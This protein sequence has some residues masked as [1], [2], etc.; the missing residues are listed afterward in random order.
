M[1]V[2]DSKIESRQD[3]SQTDAYIP[4]T[5]QHIRLTSA[6][7]AELWA[8]Y[9]SASMQECLLSYFLAKV[10]DIEIRFVLENSLEFTKKHIQRISEIYNREKYP[11]PKGITGEDV[12]IEAPRLFS[13]I[14]ILSY[15]EFMAIT[16]IIGH[17]TALATSA[18]RD[19]RHYNTESLTNAAELYNKVVSALLSKGIYIRAPYVAIPEQI[20]FVKKQS[21]LTGFLGEKRPLSSIEVSHIFSL[22]KATLI[23]KTFLTGFSQVAKSQNVRKIMVRGKDI[24]SKHSKIYA[25]LLINND[26]PVPGLWDSGITESTVT[27]FSDKLIMYVSR[28]LEVLTIQ[29]LGKAISISLRRDLV[30]SYSRVLAEIIKFAEDRVNIMIENGWLEKPPLTA[31]R[32]ALV[33]HVH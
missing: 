30:A 15:L 32:E 12:N 11:I 16:R 7:F 3:L 25:S 2:T 26:L 9:M 20:D 17:G 19:I 5:E 1:E 4:K 28:V 31:D 8:S 27:P 23:N 33:N 21:F 24:A 18:R 6:E 22:S 10:E 14:F 13:D 29:E